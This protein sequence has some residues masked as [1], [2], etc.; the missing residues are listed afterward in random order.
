MM[1]SDV[2]M[3]DPAPAPARR[4]HATP[5]DPLLSDESTIEL[6]I[7]GR[8]GDRLAAEALL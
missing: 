5:A 6:V 7:R 8:A 2:L 1:L 4:P 3:A